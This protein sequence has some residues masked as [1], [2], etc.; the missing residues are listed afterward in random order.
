MNKKRE[1]VCIACPVGCNLTV[2]EEGDEVKV[3]GN[4]CPRGKT[5]GVQEFTAPMRTVTSSVLVLRGDMDMCAVKTRKPVPKESVED[6]LECIRKLTVTAP[7][8]VGDVL[9]ADVAGTGEDLI[10]TRRIAEK[11]RRR[12]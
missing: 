3:T 2:W 1:M 9:L 5:Y 8:S 10:A 7:I 6:V 12:G 4:T 11:P